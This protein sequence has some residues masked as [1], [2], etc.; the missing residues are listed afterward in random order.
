MS[1][2]CDASLGGGD[3]HVARG[4]FRRRVTALANAGALNDP[5]GVAAERR[6]VVVR[7]DV[8]RHVA[9]GA[10]DLHAGQPPQRRADGANN[11]ASLMGGKQGAGSRE[12]GV[13]RTRL[14]T[15]SSRLPAVLADARQTRRLRACGILGNPDA[16]TQ[17]SR[18]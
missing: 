14:L 11:S 3:G 9:A 6:Q 2:D 1:A 15:P 13:M 7:D 12:R 16:V 17:F 5:I 4:H 10:D 18:T 8:V